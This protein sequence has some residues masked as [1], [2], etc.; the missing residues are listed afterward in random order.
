M[1][2]KELVQQR[3]LALMP[4]PDDIEILCAGTLLRLIEQG[5]EVCVATMTAGD[6]GSDTLT[7]TQI[8][9][10]RREEARS[11]AHLLGAARY[12]CLEFS[13]LEIVFDNN[14]RKRVTGFMRRVAPDVVFTTP[15][16]DYMFDHEITSKLVRDACFNAGCRN[17]ETE[18]ATGCEP[19]KQV[20]A[21]FYSDPIGG[22]DL[23]GIP[24]PFSCVVDI[25]TTIEKKIE[26][27]CCHDSQRAWLKRQHGMDDYV[28]SVREWAATRG[29]L[30]GSPAAEAF[31]QHLGH[32]HPTHN[33]LA[34]LP[35]TVL[36]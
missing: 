30:I 34:E 28:R 6:K 32:P 26:A 14:A 1:G 10:I 18:N 17:Y 20:P 13:D 23:F 3:I 35:G 12:T 2:A 27:L 25:Q 36:F 5:H 31:R 24:T 21:L 29:S 33:I 9:D 8:A 4:H 22:H 11:A 19:L 7:R 15:P 16:V